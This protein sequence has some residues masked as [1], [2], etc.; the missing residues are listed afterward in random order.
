M[1]NTEDYDKKVEA[2]VV[3]ILSGATNKKKP[4]KEKKKLKGFMSPSMKKESDTEDKETDMIK[5][6]AG[7]VAKVRKMRMELKDDNSTESWFITRPN[8]WDV[9]N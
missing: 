3:A 4:K 5:I 8:T 7:H 2:E 6:M 9:F 1:L